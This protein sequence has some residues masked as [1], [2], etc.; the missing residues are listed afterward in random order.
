MS[1]WFLD[2][3]LSTCLIGRMEVRYSLLYYVLL[4]SLKVLLDQSTLSELLVL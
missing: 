4:I 2:S 1:A 3:E